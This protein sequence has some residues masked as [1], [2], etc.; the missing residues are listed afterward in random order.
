MISNDLATNY[1]KW[2]DISV[3]L[4]DNDYQKDRYYTW[5]DQTKKTRLIYMVNEVMKWGQAYLINTQSYDIIATYLYSLIG[6]WLL[7]AAT[8]ANTGTGLVIGN[9]VIPTQAGGAAGSLTIQVGVLGSPIPANTNQYTNALL[10]NRVIIVILD[11]LIVQPAPITGFIYT[12]NTVTG[13]IIFN[14]NLSTGQTL[15]IVYI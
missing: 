4:S 2:A 10:I 14:S 5:T 11:N 13:T 12:F 7:S 3:Y 6:Q 1:I 15:T 8:I 9:P